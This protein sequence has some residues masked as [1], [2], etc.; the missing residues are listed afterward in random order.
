[1]ATPLIS[2]MPPLAQG[3][4]IKRYKR[5]LANIAV[6]QGSTNE[7]DELTIHCPNTG[8]MTGCAEPG[9]QVY[10]S[11]STNSKRKYPH[12]W[13]LSLTNDGHWIVVNT[14]RANQL[15][16]KQLATGTL[17]GLPPFNRVISEIKF[18]NSR[19]DFGLLTDEQHIHYVEVKSVTLNDQGNG[20]FPD[21]VSL[22]GQ[23][24]LQE[25]MSIVEQGG[26]ATLF[27]A[28]MHSGIERVAAAKHVDP[29]YARLLTLAAQKGVQI[30]AWKAAISSTGLSWAC[31]LPVIIE[32]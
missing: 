20:Y 25:L 29:E 21:A 11:Q 7:V 6:N 26:S 19:L 9:Y 16:A 24:H 17:S 1:M 30:I 27:F 22:R 18:G 12:T 32:N 4:L 10:Y 14:Q 15:L 5:F 2:F 31:R 3:T 28:V 8:A 13:E 23:K